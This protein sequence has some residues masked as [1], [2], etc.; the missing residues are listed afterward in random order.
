[1][2][3]L[4]QQNQHTITGI[5]IS[6]EK[7]PYGQNNISS[8]DPTPGIIIAIL[9]ISLLGFIIY[10]CDYWTKKFYEHKVEMDK[11]SLNNKDMQNFTNII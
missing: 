10:K 7:I 1:M 6:P 4:N 5:T 2:S 3:N 11:L 8:I 9:F